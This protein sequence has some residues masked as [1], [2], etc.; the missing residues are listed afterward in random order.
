[1]AS[2][3]QEGQAARC[4]YRSEAQP[5]TTVDWVLCVIVLAVPLVGAWVFCRMAARGDQACRADVQERRAARDARPFTSALLSV[6]PLGDGPA[7]PDGG[8]GLS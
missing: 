1:M 6:E 8:D 4:P 5:M 7:A 2:E 3:G